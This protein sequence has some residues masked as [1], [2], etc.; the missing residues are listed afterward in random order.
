VLV[1][2]GSSGLQFAKEKAKAHLPDRRDLGFNKASVYPGLGVSSPARLEK[3][4]PTLTLMVVE[5]TATFN[6][7]QMG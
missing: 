7:S 6:R 4:E 5:T 3:N 2:A 1:L